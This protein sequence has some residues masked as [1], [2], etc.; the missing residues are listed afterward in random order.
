MKSGHDHYNGIWGNPYYDNE[1][2]SLA[3]LV[4]EHRVFVKGPA[5]VARKAKDGWTTQKEYKGEPFDD[6]EWR[7]VEKGWDHQHCRVCQFSIEEGMT[8]WITQDEKFIL[9][10]ACHEHYSQK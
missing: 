9:C 7:L 2:I 5:L 3:N 4:F 10:D 6:S 8:Y 1:A